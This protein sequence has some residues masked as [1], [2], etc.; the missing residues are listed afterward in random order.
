VAPI[1]GNTTQ[2]H[3]KTEADFGVSP[4]KLLTM[5]V[6]TETAQNFKEDAT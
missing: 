5:P 3:A 1:E 6:R 4:T 2:M